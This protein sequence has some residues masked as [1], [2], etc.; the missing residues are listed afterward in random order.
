MAAEAQSQHEMTL[1]EVDSRAVE[2]WTCGQ[3]ARIVLIEWEPEFQRTVVQAG[4]ETA[5][6]SGGK[7]GLKFGTSTAEVGAENLPE[8]EQNWLSGIGVRW[9]EPRNR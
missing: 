7:G 9:D 6:H 4:D 5:L 3:C 8:S 1:R 2:R